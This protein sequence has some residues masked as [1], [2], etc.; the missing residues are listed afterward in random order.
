ME[1]KKMGNDYNQSNEVLYN[2]DNDLASPFGP[3]DQRG[4]LNYIDNKKVINA[5]KI[6]EKGKVYRMS[7][8]VFN[9]MADRPTHGPYFFD[10]LLRPYDNGFTEKY[11]NKYG[12]SLGRI[13]MCDHTG[14]HLDA[15]SHMAYNNKFYNNINVNEII[16]NTGYKKLGIENAGPA[17]TKGIMVDAAE[18]NGTDVLEGGYAI[19]E[20]EVKKFLKDNNIDLEPGDAIFFHTGASKF[21][22]EPEKYDKFYDISAGI[23]YKL[24]KYLEHMKVSITGSDTPSSEVVPPENANTRLPVHQYLIAKAGIYIIDNLSLHR[25]AKDKV[26]KFLFVCSPI[27]FKGATASPVSPLAII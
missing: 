17:V 3:D 19:T 7:H 13:E 23:G 14:T 22:S 5:L 26:Y 20:N 10:L 1:K 27:P 4:N 12:P 21:F 18:A 8:T 2:T 9:G 24:A 6:P 16:T 11:E 25:M 15:L